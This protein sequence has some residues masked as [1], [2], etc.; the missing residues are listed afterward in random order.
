MLLPGLS[1]AL[2]DY[3]AVQGISKAIGPLEKLEEQ[4]L[5]ALF[6]KAD[7]IASLTSLLRRING[8]INSA[9]EEI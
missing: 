7:D 2:S 8:D 6:K 3:L 1:Y 4:N 9:V 5:V